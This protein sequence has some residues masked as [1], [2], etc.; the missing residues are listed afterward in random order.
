M[1]KYINI[2]LPS[3]IA[4]WNFIFVEKISKEAKYGLSSLFCLLFVI[5]EMSQKRK[6][7]VV[8][9]QVTN[10][11]MYN[12]YYGFFK[13]VLTLTLLFILQWRY[14]Q[15]ILFNQSVNL[16]F[17]CTCRVQR[18]LEHV[19]RVSPENGPTLLPM[20]TDLAHSLVCYSSDDKTAAED[21][22][23]E[24]HSAI[25]FLAKLSSIIAVE[26]P[27]ACEDITALQWRE[28]PLIPVTTELHEASK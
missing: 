14:N 8:N 5:E 16:Y 11:Y 10:M 3:S 26:V 28:L 24:C 18:V 15:Y 19:M 7:I 22:H 20:A 9:S 17:V 2:S 27:G 13:E 25:E 23:T 21:L 6:L 1:N 12:K 4:I